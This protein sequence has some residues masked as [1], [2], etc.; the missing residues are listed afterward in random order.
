MVTSISKYKLMH[1]SINF[2]NRTVKVH[3]Y[4]RNSF[5]TKKLSHW[6]Q[7]LTILFQAQAY[8]CLYLFLNTGNIHSKSSYPLQLL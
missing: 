6:Y 4:G 5:V 7:M 2:L 1:V 8:T 3:S